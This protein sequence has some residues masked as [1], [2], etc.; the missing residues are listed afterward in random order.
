MDN[1]WQPA[2]G[3]DV[4]SQGKGIGW[5]L[6]LTY[7]SIGNRILK[8]VFQV[9]GLVCNPSRMAGVSPYFFSMKLCDMLKISSLSSSPVF[10]FAKLRAFLV[11]QDMRSRSL[12][13]NPSM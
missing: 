11:K 4:R 12:L 2:C 13:Q 6:E 10:L 3:C 7:F 9:S 1:P 5:V 8:N